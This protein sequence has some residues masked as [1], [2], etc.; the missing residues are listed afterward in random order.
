MT[1]LAW[2]NLIYDRVR[3]TITL[4]GIAFAVTLV[5]VQ[6]GLMLGMLANASVTIEHLKADL[7]VTSQNTPNVDFAHPFPESLLQRVRSTPGVRRADNLIVTNMEITLPSGAQEGALVYGLDHFARWGIPWRVEGGNPEDLRRGPYVLIDGSG[8]KRYGPFAIGDH[9]L[10]QGRRFEIIGKTAGARSFT[11]TPISFM[12]PEHIRD[13]QPTRLAGQTTYV[14]VA[15]E[16]GANREQ[17]A[18]ELARRLPHNSVLTRDAWARRSQMY[19]VTN[20]G[21]GL[22]MVVTVLLGCLVGTVVVGQT[23]YTGTVEHIREFGTLKAI[24]AVN[25][26]IFAVLLQQGS[27]AAL[28]G[29]GLG[30]LTSFGLRALVAGAGLDVRIP[31]IMIGSV[32]L[33]ALVV[34]LLGASLCYRRIATIDPALVFRT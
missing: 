32:L 23:L 5:L 2:K 17:V 24:G 7:W 28:L 3:L 13:L 18:S 30:L 14:L 15:L 19:W 31:P 16:P 11:T 29:F 1:G 33:G 25:R 9:R 34:C 20:T 22:N 8:A 4:L 10:Y 26:E 6:V 27:F 21:I 12:S